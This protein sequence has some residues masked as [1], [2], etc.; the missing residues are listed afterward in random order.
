MSWRDLQ[1]L[2][3][4]HACS[5]AVLYLSITY[6]TNAIVI[7]ILLLT[8]RT[9]CLRRLAGESLRSVYAGK[10]YSGYT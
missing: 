5:G 10:A 3:H 8:V 4:A 1:G 7:G 6:L 2:A 9:T